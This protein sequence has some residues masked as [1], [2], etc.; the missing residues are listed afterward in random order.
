MAQTFKSGKEEQ[1]DDSETHWV[2]LTLTQVPPLT[3]SHSINKCK[4]N[5]NTKSLKTYERQ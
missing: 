5:L 4:R 1:R 3:L 2:L